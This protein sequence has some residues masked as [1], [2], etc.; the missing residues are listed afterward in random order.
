MSL[1]GARCVLRATFATEP[2]C[3]EGVLVSNQ[4]RKALCFV[5]MKNWRR[6]RGRVRV[7]VGVRVRV[8]NRVSVVLRVDEELR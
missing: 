5:L 1:G 8:R 3:L 2:A 6:V 4:S 7:G